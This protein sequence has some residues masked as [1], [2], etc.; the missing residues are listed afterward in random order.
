[1]SCPWDRN[2]EHHTASGNDFEVAIPSLI[3]IETRGVN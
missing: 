3:D 1:M 2:V